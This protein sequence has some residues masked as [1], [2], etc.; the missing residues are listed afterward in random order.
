ME[1]LITHTSTGTYVQSGK[2][3]EGHAEL[4]VMGMQGGLNLCWSRLKQD[5]TSTGTNLP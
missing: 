5:E 1:G 2:V 3:R 4:L